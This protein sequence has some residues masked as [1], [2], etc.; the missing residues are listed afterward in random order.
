MGLR[1]EAYEKQYSYKVVFIELYRGLYEA[2]NN[3]CL[4]MCLFRVLCF[5]MFLKMTQENHNSKVM[6]K[7]HPKTTSWKWSEP[8]IA[9]RQSVY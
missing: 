6:I 4:P 2:H 1:V 5:F 8:H 7:K 3:F 9:E